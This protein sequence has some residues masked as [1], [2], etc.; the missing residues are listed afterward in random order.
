[1]Q[2]NFNTSN[3]K[4]QAEEQ[5]LVAAG[6]AAALLT[7]VAKTIDAMTKRRYARVWAKEVAR[8]SKTL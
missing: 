6:V 8:R 7:G 4:R 2:F 3:L 5:P 1:M